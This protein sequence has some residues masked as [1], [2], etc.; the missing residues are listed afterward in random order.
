MSDLELI[1]KENCNAYES[2]I[3]I[4]GRSLPLDEING[5]IKQILEEGFTHGCN[6]QKDSQTL[7]SIT[8]EIGINKIHAGFFE[9]ERIHEARKILS[10]YQEKTFSKWIQLLYGNRQTAYNYLSIYEFTLS[11]PPEK[12]S[13][14]NKIPQQSVTALASR[15]AP[16]HVKEEILDLIENKTKEEGLEIIRKN[17]PLPIYDKRRKKHY[18]IEFQNLLLKFIKKY[19]LNLDSV[20]SLKKELNNFIK[21]YY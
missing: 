1:F 11:L 15:T 10:K 9:G 3:K 7:I 8:R 19:D 2:T 14:L 21:Q 5:M 17:I 13:I 16:T 18:S 4:L 20:Q 12:R 6:V